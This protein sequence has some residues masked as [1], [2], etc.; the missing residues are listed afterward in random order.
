VSFTLPCIGPFSQRSQWCVVV[1]VSVQALSQLS[2]IYRLVITI[3]LGV[4]VYAA[5]SAAVNRKQLVDLWNLVCSLRRKQ[6]A[7]LVS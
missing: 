2:P 3:G 7:Q 1:V 6:A 4:A 5:M